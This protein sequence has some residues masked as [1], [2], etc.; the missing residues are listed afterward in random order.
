MNGKGIFYNSNG[1]KYD[2]EWKDDVKHGYGK[3]Y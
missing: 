3:Y 1:G 2:G